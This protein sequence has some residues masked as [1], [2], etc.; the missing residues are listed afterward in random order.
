MFRFGVLQQC[1]PA[2]IA[3]KWKKNRTRV[4]AKM[5]GWRASVFALIYALT[6]HWASSQRQSEHTIE[7]IMVADCK[8]YDE[9][10]TI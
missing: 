10:Q 1:Q 5:S 6:Q 4:L 8:V 7:Q 2:E 9:S 3:A